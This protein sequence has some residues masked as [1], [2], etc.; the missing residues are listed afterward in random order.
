MYRE[1]RGT[2][3]DL[4]RAVGIYKELSDQGNLGAM[5]NLINL[6]VSGDITDKDVF[7]F[8]K[9][10]MI[11]LANNANAD[12]N[13]RLGGY[14]YE[15]YGVPTDYAEALRWYERAA[16]LG[17]SWCKQKVLQLKEKINTT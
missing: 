8:A 17:D 15:G 13:K 1:G 4:D 14:Y 11:A 16:M 10:R 2:K 6:Y 5:V 3:K 9:D 12:A 7:E